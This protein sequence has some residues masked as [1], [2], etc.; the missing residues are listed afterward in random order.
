MGSHMSSMKEITTKRCYLIAEIGQ[1]HQG[2]LAL[3]KELVHAAAQCGVDAVKSHKRDPSTFQE[4]EFARPY[5]SPHSFGRT[6]GEH[7]RRLELSLEQHCILRDYALSQGLTY[8]CSVWDVGSA[9]LLRSAGFEI[10]K[11]PSARLRDTELLGLVSTFGTPVILSTGMATLDDVRRAVGILN[12]S[13]LYLLQCTSSYPTDPADVNLLVLRVFRR[14]FQCV[15]GISAHYT[16][17]AVDLAAIALGAR[18]L[19]RHFT[20]DRGWKGRDH[21]LSLDR[22]GLRRWVALVRTG[23][24]ALGSEVKAI[25]ACEQDALVRF[26]LRATCEELGLHASEV[27]ENG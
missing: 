15:V 16:E 6:Y 25:L 5:V 11:I 22:E 13:E 20:L 4:Q 10:F 19:E 27:V 18:V 7:R 2:S 23:E 12:H 17:P 1:N 3:A 24:A 14:L 21:C 8:F 26:G 9:A